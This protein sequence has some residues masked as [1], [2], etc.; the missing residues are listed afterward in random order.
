MAI[1]FNTDPYYDDYNEDKNFHRILF[2]PG[3]A[4]QARELTQLQTILQ[5]QITR[6]GKSIYKDGSMVVPGTILYDKNLNYVK[7]APTYN[8]TDI[9]VANYLG[10]ELIG[11]T[12]GIRAKVILTDIVPALGDTEK[13][14]NSLKSSD[15]VNSIKCYSGK[16]PK[17]YNKFEEIVKYLRKSIRENTI[18]ATIGAGDIY[19]IKDLYVKNLKFN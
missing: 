1:N 12:S 16:S 14:I 2:K 8:S 7:L 4:V 10:R 11:A 17:I 9:D 18:I 15:V 5:N 19:K 13:D 6:F 3:V